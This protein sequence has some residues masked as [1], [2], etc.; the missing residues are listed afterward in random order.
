MQAA[1]AGLNAV[2]SWPKLNLWRNGCSQLAGMA[3]VSLGHGNG[4]WQLS[5]I[6]I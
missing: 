2:A 6:N 4:N 1:S 3:N 5:K